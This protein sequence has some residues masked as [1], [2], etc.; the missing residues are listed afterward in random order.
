MDEDTDTHPKLY[1]EYLIQLELRI[2][3]PVLT[4]IILTIQIELMQVSSQIVVITKRLF[5]INNS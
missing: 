4:S 3:K 5:Q 2:C 1:F